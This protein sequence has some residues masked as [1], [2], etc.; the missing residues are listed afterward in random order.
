MPPIDVD[1]SVS[2]T[3]RARTAGQSAMQT[4]LA[5]QGDAPHRGRI[6][7]ALGR[8][9]LHPDAVSWYDEALAERE[10]GRRLAAL[11]SA[12]TVLH[13]LPIGAG[14]GGEG[15][16]GGDGR[17]VGDGDGH[18]SGAAHSDVE[19][20]VIGPAGVFC[21]NSTRSATVSAAQLEAVAVQARAVSKH[22][23]RTLQR[24][25]PVIPL[26]VTAGGAEPK[27]AALAM[28]A[29]PA[30]A[31]TARAEPKTTPVAAKAAPAAS[32]PAP[33]RE[34]DVVAVRALAGWFAKRG[35]VLT[36]AE[37]ATLAL[38]AEQPGTWRASVSELDRPV[39]VE[40]FEE[41]QS[42]V[43]AASERERLALVVALTVAVIVVLVA[44]SVIVASMNHGIF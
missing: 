38:A 6:A 22:L 30:A 3:L 40:D 41:L 25:V 36:T 13:S 14:D 16:G 8:S 2:P 20:L 32:K 5:L 42:E 9:P 7:R 11:G 18:D 24:V 37:L 33:V 12:Y 34:V 10:T 35:P 19:H 27:K 15:D 17:G 21:L 26:L 31:K 23:S 28:K 43:D 4:C 39:A 29:A 1:R 44:A